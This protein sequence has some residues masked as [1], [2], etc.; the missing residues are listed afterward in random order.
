MNFV[1]KS[2]RKY[3]GFHATDIVLIAIP[4]AEQELLLVRKSGHRYWTKR[5]KFP[6][7]CVGTFG[8][9]SVEITF[10][11]L[12]LG[13]LT[14]NVKKQGVWKNY[15]RWNGVRSGELR[16]TLSELADIPSGRARTR[17]DDSL[18]EAWWSE[19]KFLGTETVT[20]LWI[21]K[22]IAEIRNQN[23]FSTGKINEQSKLYLF[24]F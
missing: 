13:T 12:Y 7:K 19:K 2:S 4:A 8:Q 6:P 11:V 24:H 23:F 14:R 5:L 1:K 3:F 16:S 21:T 18:L 20:F 9:H 22:K 17:S 10:S 15:L